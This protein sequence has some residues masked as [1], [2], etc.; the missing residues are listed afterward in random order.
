MDNLSTVVTGAGRGLGRAMALGLLRA[1]HCV[2]AIDRDRSELDALERDGVNANGKLKCMAL[3]LTL[4]DSAK[5]IVDFAES[6][7]GPI[8]CLVNCAGIGQEIISAKFTSEPV[9]FWTVDE[10]IWKRVFAVN[11]D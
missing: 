4:A 3:D 2:V 5:S 7:F 1:G 11:A 9:K 6:Q 10:D 8:A